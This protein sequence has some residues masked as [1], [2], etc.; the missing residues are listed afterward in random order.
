MELEPLN[1]KVITIVAGIISSNFHANIGQ[2]E[3]FSLPPGSMY[4]SME[5]II[6]EKVK[7]GALSSKPTSAEDFAE[8]VVKNVLGGRTGKTY[9]GA[10]AWAAKWAIWWFPGWLFVSITKSMYQKGG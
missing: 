5:G 2:P 10:L 3:N 4:K 7:G 9:S 1:V 6:R 8:E